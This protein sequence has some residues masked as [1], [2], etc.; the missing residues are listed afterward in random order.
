MSG[1]LI[2]KTFDKTLEMHR[3]NV[4]P[5]SRQRTTKRCQERTPRVRQ[6]LSAVG[7]ARDVFVIPSGAEISAAHHKWLA[8]TQA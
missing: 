7:D 4:R 2:A 5:I 3:S 6:Q 1:D 8:G